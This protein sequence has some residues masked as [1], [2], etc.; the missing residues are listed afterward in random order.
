MILGGFFCQTAFFNFM[1]PLP[2]LLI[3]FRSLKIHKLR[4]FLTVLG[5]VIG[6]TSVI[7]V[8]SAG[9]GLK[10]LLL[11]QIESWGSNFLEVEVK[12]PST[13]KTSM[14]NATSMMMG[15]NIT[16]LTQAD[17]EAIKRYANIGNVYSA[18]IGQ[19]MVIRGQEAAMKQLWGVSASFIDI[20]TS[21]VAEGRFFTDEEDKNI[22]KVAV[23][24]QTIKEN[25]FAGQDPLGQYLKIGKNNYKVIGVLEDKGAVMYMDMDDVIYLP[26]TTLQKLVMGVDHVMFIMGNLKNQQLAQATADDLTQIMR[27]RHDIT[28]PNKDDFAVTTM[29]EMM[30]IWGTIF[31]AVT[32]LLMAIVAVSL[33]VGGVGIMNIMFV[34]IT[35]RTAEI[36]LSKAVGARPQSILAQFLWEAVALTSIGGVLGIVLGVLFSWLIALGAQSQGWD[37]PFVVKPIALA[38]AVGVSVAIGLIFGLYPAQK[39]AKKDP[40]EALRFEH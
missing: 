2:S 30:Q 31:D 25:Y 6:I 13:S 3:A 8:F 29:E 14:S 38:I 28:D 39:A 17:A 18:I 27:E 21:E 19:A 1:N 23:I 16:T 4:S 40:I 15:V 33:I 26:L 5:I 22:S 12:T 9:E 11:S 36:G 32:L 10:G 37:W 20:D 35:E 24:G 7:I 34:S